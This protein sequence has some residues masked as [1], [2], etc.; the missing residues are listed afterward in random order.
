MTTETK[1]QDQ[2]TQPDQ[3]LQSKKKGI[4]LPVLINL[5]LFIGLLVL[6]GLFFLRPGKPADQA[7][8]YPAEG[9]SSG[10]DASIVFVRSDILLEE[11]EL[12]IKLRSDFEQE[13]SRLET[14]L[15]RR[16]RSFQTELEGFQR[17]LNAGILSLDKAQE[18][19]QELMVKQQELMQ[20]ADTYRERL[21]LMEMDMNRELLGKISDFLESYNLESGYD[22]ILGYARGGGILHAEARYDITDDVLKRL[23]AEFRAG[24]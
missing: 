20:L 3:E 11:Y 6:Y 21:A 1:T 5:L 22:Y 13:Q 16:Q 8:A 9:R 4:S 19:E 12:A 14:D 18:R 24:Q 17:S 2:H 7:V 10:M 15:N 23:N